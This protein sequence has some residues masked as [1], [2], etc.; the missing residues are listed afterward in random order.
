MTPVSKRRIPDGYELGELRAK[1]W[2]VGHVFA[3]SEVYGDYLDEV[4]RI[5]VK[6]GETVGEAYERETGGESLLNFRDVFFVKE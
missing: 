1:T 6:P 4:H 2:K 3:W 5:T